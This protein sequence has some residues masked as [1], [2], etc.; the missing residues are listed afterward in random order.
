MK[1]NKLLLVAIGI[2]V[3]SVTCVFLMHGSY[4]PKIKADSGFDTSYD[5]GGSS[6]DSGGS[7]WDS[8]SSRSSSDSSG[9]GGDGPTPLQ[10]L[11][12]NDTFAYW[13]RLIRNIFYAILFP[14]VGVMS[15]I[16]KQTRVRDR[17]KN[18]FAALVILA[19]AF[20]L[21]EVFIIITL[22]ALSFVYFLIL[23][24]T[25]ELKRSN[26]IP[27]S[28]MPRKNV[29]E[30]L[31]TKYNT[32][33]FLNGRYDDYLKVQD[34][35][36]NF[37]YDVLKEKLTDELYNQYSMQ[38]DT[39][40]VKNQKNVMKNFEYIKSKVTYVSEENDVISVTLELV[41]K[42]YDYIEENGKVVRGSN[43]RIV[44]QHY[45]MVFVSS[46]GPKHCNNCGAEL[47]GTIMKEC[48]YCKS[49]LIYIPKTWV[50]SK[51]RSIS[52]S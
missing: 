18:L 17:F 52:Q 12:E 21:S 25:A 39:L 24:K 38:L 5:S 2:L 20:L 50:L 27:V 30:K 31:L 8:G 26:I 3:F 7:S 48:P 47:D 11:L 42:F 28:S 34:A 41:V 19:F 14:V 9:G 32:E 15:F 44:T 23:P 45:E 40:K 49:K 36:M 13:Y 51:K 1:I 4:L 16:K 37:N 29:D 43:K 10:Q 22:F 35:W 6:W 46:D 33:E